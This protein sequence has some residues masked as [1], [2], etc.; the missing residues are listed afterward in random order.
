[1]TN[2]CDKEIRLRKFGFGGRDIAGR[3]AHKPVAVSRRATEALPLPGV[4][5]PIVRVFIDV[6]ILL[7]VAD[8]H[9]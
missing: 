5:T 9:R 3:G 7:T 8:P 6:V 1:M 4:I 2:I